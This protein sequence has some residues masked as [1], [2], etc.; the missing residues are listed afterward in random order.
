MAQRIPIYGR[1]ELENGQVVR[2][3]RF[4]ETAAEAIRVVT[5]QYVHVVRCWQIDPITGEPFTSE[6][7]PAGA[8]AV[9]FLESN[10]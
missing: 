10:Q 4:E 7:E 6:K 8:D 3:L 5:A 9:E 1:V 2:W